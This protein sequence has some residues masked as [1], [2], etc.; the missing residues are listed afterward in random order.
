MVVVV[1]LVV[2]VDRVVR[3]LVRVVVGRV[4]GLAR[5]DVSAVSYVGLFPRRLSL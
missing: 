3:L 2:V 4:V 1:V 5:C